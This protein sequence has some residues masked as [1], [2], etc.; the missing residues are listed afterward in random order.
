MI[1]LLYIPFCVFFAWLNAQW[2]AKGKKILH[3]INGSI[4]LFAAIIIGYSTKWQY[5]LA[6]LFITRLFFDVSLNL[7]RKLPV[8]YISPE[9]KAY[10]NFWKA[11]WKGK[12]VDYIEYKLFG[13]NG[14]LPKIIYALIIV[15]LLTV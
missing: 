11:V 2:I 15:I 3:G 5:G 13:N 1:V 4:H 7:F 6:V 9:V 12:V 14:Y 8:D 10:K